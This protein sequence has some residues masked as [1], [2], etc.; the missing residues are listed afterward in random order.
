MN[1]IT[2][3]EWAETFKEFLERERIWGRFVFNLNKKPDRLSPI[4]L[5][6]CYSVDTFNREG[7]HTMFFPFR[8]FR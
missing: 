2:Q 7:S 6:Y 4:R 8:L 5:V 1:K 3:K